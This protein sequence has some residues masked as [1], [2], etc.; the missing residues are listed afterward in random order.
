MADLVSEP[1]SCAV[2]FVFPSVKELLTSASSALYLGISLNSQIN[3]VAEERK[4]IRFQNNNHRN[5]IYIFSN[6]SLL[7]LI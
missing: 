6:E 7:L 1:I 2:C 3:S 5:I 4:M